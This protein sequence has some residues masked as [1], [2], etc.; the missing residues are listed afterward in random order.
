MADAGPQAPNIPVLLF[1]LAQPVLQAPQQ[2]K[3]LAPQPQQGQHII[4][5]NWSHFKPEFSRKPEEDAE[6]YLL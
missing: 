1:T 2:L 4:N 3:L 6:M 5:I